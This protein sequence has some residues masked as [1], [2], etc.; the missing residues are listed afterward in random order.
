MAM[1]GSLIDVTIVPVIPVLTQVPANV[2]RET[3][4]HDPLH[5]HSSPGWSACVLDSACPS[6]VQPR[7]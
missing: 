4:E 2:H 6:P 5:S 3:Q 7:P 1:P